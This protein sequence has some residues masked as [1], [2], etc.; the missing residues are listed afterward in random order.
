MKNCK[1]CLLITSSIE[2]FYEKSEK[3]SE[4]TIIAILTPIEGIQLLQKMIPNPKKDITFLKKSSFVIDNINQRKPETDILAA[5]I[6]NN[7]FN[8]DLVK[9]RAKLV[10]LGTYSDSRFLTIFDRHCDTFEV[11]IIA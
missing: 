7:V 3:K 8:I 2:K 6:L 4:P 10:L 5:N 1:D 9:E 11:P